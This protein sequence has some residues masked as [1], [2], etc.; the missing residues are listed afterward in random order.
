[1]V[2][3]ADEWSVV[4]TILPE[5]GPMRTAT[6]SAPHRFSVSGALACGHSRR[7]RRCSES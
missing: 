5:S 3:Q 4:G 6:Q 7:S 2:R 1:M